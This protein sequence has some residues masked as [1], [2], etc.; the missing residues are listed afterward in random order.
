MVATCR[1]LVKQARSRAKL[2]VQAQRRMESWGGGQ[3]ILSLF[4]TMIQVAAPAGLQSQECCWPPLPVSLPPLCLSTFP[5]CAPRLADGLQSFLRRKALIHHLL[6]VGRPMGCSISE[7]IEKWN[8]GLQL[9]ENTICRPSAGVP[10]ALHLATFSPGPSSFP[11]DQEDAEHI[12]PFFA[13]C[14]TWFPTPG[15]SSWNCGYW[16]CKDAY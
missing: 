6:P 1:L 12:S 13:N 9:D 2:P 8:W 5:T 15:S 16:R 7:G 10:V 11:R 4:V 14:Q 3:G